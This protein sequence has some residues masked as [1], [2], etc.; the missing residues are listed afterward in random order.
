MGRFTN[1]GIAEKASSVGGF[2]Q[3]GALAAS[4]GIKERYDASSLNRRQSEP[5]TT[6]TDP[7]VPQTR[8]APPIK[9]KPSLAP[10]PQLKPKPGFQG[11]HPGQDATPQ[12]APSL[13]AASVEK[14]TAPAVEKATKQTFAVVQKHT[15]KSMQ[16]AIMAK[17]VTPHLGSSQFVQKRTAPLVEKATNQMYSSA[18]KQAEASVQ[19]AIVSTVV[20]QQPQTTGTKAMQGG[21]Q[22]ALPAGLLSKPLTASSVEKATAPTVQ[23]A[24]HQSFTV[25]QKHTEKSMQQAIMSKVITP[26]LGSSKFVQKR[27][28]PL[29]EKAT[30]QIYASAEKQAEASVQNAIVMTVVGQ[31]PNPSSPEQ[32]TRDVPTKQPS[33]TSQAL[34]GKMSAMAKSTLAKAHMPSPLRNGSEGQSNHSLTHLA[35]EPSRTGQSA[36]AP[37]VP[38]AGRKSFAG[39]IKSKLGKARPKSMNFDV[40][41]HKNDHGDPGRT[42]PKEEGHEGVGKK[43]PPPRP[44]TGPLRS[45]GKLLSHARLV[46]CLC[47]DTATSECCNCIF[48]RQLLPISMSIDFH[49]PFVSDIPTGDVFP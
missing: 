5:D 13:T 19:Q 42:Q 48:S 32:P 28:A 29:V 21:G 40:L 7:V 43:K 35:P 14:A 1:G 12:V 31:Q 16:Q 15:E 18:Q 49:G 11:G 23:K 25:I 37:D 6:K 39:G 44:S 45:A 4:K 10:K 3:A 22:P 27:S 33:A 24:T 17:F 41:R 9:P 26:H 46:S 36:E 8:T 47:V 2:L 20:G 34:P 38:M 30:N